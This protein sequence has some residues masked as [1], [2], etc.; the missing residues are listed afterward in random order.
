[1]TK[2]RLTAT[3]PA[4]G[5]FFNPPDMR[6]VLDFA[7]AA[8]A[9]GIGG[10][11]AVDH[12]VLGRDMSAYKWGPYMHAPDA[13]FPE[14]LVLLAAAAAVTERVTLESAIVIAPIRPAVLLAKQAATMDLLARGRFRLGVGAG[15]Q[16]AELESAGVPFGE[17]GLRLTETIEACRLLWRESPASYS[18][19]FVRFKEVY[20]EPRPTNGSVPVWFAG[21]LHER[22]LRR[23]VALGDGWIPIMGTGADE[24]AAGVARL[25]EALIAAGRDSATVEVS[26]NVPPVHRGERADLAATLESAR[27]LGEVGV[28]TVN[29]APSAYT[30][31]NGASRWVEDAAARWER[32]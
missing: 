28:T 29:L 8:D 20:C 32:L 23:I 14:P 27:A 6:R 9:A 26:F 4:F 1:M 30:V 16:P 11:K 15:W 17:R 22:N 3:L 21:P 18:G 12:V 19:R 7:R 13:P 25:R 5:A 2:P 10:L 31:P 24:L